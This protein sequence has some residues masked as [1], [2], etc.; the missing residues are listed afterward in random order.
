MLGLT[1]NLLYS[2]LLF[3]KLST[4]NLA[5]LINTVT[6]ELYEYPLLGKLYNTTSGLLLAPT[7]VAEALILLESN[8]NSFL[9]SY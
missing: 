4:L 9:G 7:K 5:S 1:C 3:K 6:D 2:G 8:E